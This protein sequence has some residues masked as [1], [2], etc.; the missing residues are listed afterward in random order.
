MDPGQ[1]SNTEFTMVITINEHGIVT[2]ATDLDG[3]DLIFD[4]ENHELKLV[5]NG[6]QSYKPDGDGT[7]CWRVVAGVPKCRLAYCAG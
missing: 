4:P 3:K 7:C 2:K 1:S 5:G 6:L